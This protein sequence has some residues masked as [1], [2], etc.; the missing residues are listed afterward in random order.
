[1]AGGE[2]SDGK[3]NSSGRAQATPAADVG[4]PLEVRLLSR[5]SEDVKPGNGRANGAKR[6]SHHGIVLLDSSS[7]PPTADPSETA[8]TSAAAASTSSYD[9]SARLSTDPLR[10]EW[11]RCLDRDTSAFEI[12]SSSANTSAR[13]SPAAG[14]G[15]GAGGDV[16][17]LTFDSDNENS[18]P[19][20][21]TRPAP[22][23]DADHH[24]PPH[25]RP[26]S[27]STLSNHNA[28]SG[29]RGN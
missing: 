21:P 10:H 13:N 12:L 17:D 25:P 28:S 24:Q 7:P 2:T 22:S 5:D 6:A 26:A 18:E 8:S 16:I 19:S 27:S 11:R 20:V 1:M 4:I 15:A 3:I 14:A 9:T 23:N 29:S